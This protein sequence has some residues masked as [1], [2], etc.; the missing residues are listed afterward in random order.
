MSEGIEDLDDQG[1][2]GALSNRNVLFMKH[3]NKHTLYQHKFGV[4]GV[5]SSA[6]SV[7]LHSHHSSMSLHP[8]D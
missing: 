7:L 2:G 8:T 1:E 3:N 4:G 5:K 6:S